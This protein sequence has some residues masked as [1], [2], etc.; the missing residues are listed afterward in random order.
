MNWL[1]EW[2]NR[3][4]ELWQQVRAH[5][6]ALKGGVAVGLLIL[7]LIFSFALWPRTPRPIPRV[8][9]L[10]GDAQKVEALRELAGDDPA[11][12]KARDL[13]GNTPLHIAVL[14]GSVES[15]EALL[16]AGADVHTTNHHGWTP[17]ESALYGSGD[18]AGVARALLTAGAN[19][20][21]RSADGNTLLHA[22]VAT[23]G[24]QPKLVALLARD[25]SALVV[26]NE[27]GQTPLEVARAWGRRKIVKTLEDARSGRLSATAQ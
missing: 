27:Q 9:A 20:G 26:R 19:A 8:F 5:P 2:W 21:Q 25:P 15:V 4:W 10:A 18:Q 7:A 11:V 17:L 6:G 13:D 22:A 3:D 14:S 23:P 1:N 16:A 12:L 24:V